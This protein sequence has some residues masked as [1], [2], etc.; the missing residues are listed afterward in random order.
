[1]SAAWIVLGVLHA[2]KYIWT[3]SVHLVIIKTVL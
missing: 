1:M 3:A 2:Y